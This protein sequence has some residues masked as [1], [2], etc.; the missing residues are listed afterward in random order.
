M[1]QGRAWP[2]GLLQLRNR[3]PVLLLRMLLRH[4]VLLRLLWLV[5]VVLLRVRM[6]LVVRRHGP[7]RALTGLLLL[8]LLLH[9]LLVL[10]MG[11]GP[12]VLPRRLRRQR[13][14]G[15]PRLPLTLP[16]RSALLPP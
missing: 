13:V 1:L 2:A 15:L 16:V 7:F 11:L 5:L 10:G 14:V 8:L 12:R 3:G 9:H 6:L 4:V